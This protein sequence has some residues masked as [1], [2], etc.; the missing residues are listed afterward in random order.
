LHWQDLSGKWL[1]GLNRGC[2]TNQQF[3]YQ[4]FPQAV[5]AFLVGEL[6]IVI[7]TGMQRNIHIADIMAE[8]GCIKKDTVF[9]AFFESFVSF[10][11]I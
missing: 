2:I 7:H 3:G 10:P 11:F 1:C 8:I 4:R 9:V 5:H 6:P